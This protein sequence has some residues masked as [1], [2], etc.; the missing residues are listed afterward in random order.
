MKNITA[1]VTQLF[2]VHGICNLFSIS[3][4]PGTEAVLTDSGK[5]KWNEFNA[6]AGLSL[7]LNFSGANNT[8]ISLYLLLITSTT[9]NGKQI[10]KNYLT[11]LTI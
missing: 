3:I 6:S 10:Q 7:P 1:L 4:K 9:S 2:T 5:V 8:A 11:I